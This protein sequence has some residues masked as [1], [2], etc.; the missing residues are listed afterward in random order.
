MPVHEYQFFLRDTLGD[1]PG[2]NPL[3]IPLEDTLIVGC[4]LNYG[5]IFCPALRCLNSNISFTSNDPA[6]E[7]RWRIYECSDLI[8]LAI[9]ASHCRMQTMTEI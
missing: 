6:L 9:L 3:G 2:G 1:T 4:E 8:I 5:V 7:R